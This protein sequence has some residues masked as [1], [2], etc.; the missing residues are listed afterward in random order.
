MDYRPLF[1]AWFFNAELWYFQPR[2]PFWEPGIWIWVPAGLGTFSGQKRGPGKHDFV[3]GLVS[4]GVLGGSVRGDWIVWYPGG[5]W[6]R[7]F[8]PK[9]YQKILFPTFPDFGKVRGP[10][11]PPWWIPYSP[12]VGPW[13][14]AGVGG[15]AAG[16]FY[17]VI[18]ISSVGVL[19]LQA[20]SLPRSL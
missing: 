4:H 8:P 2:R 13:P 3:E 20:A 12:F 14:V 11:C 17:Y 18:G 10:P 19:A 7:P 15:M 1:S 16:L 6:A 5:L 9:P